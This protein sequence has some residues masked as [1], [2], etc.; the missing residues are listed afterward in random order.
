M[1]M[2]LLT[3]TNDRIQ[4]ENKI[5]VQRMATME[6]GMKGMEDTLRLAYNRI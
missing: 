3:D 1:K 5:L 4:T 6:E 2:K